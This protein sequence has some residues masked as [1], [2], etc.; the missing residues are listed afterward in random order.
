MIIGVDSLEEAIEY[1]KDSDI[2][3]ELIYQYRKIIPCLDALD[4]VASL[5]YD[6]EDKLENIKAKSLI[7]G[8]DDF[9]SFNTKNDIL[10]LKDMIKDLKII[11]KY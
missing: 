7:I 6:L 5:E 10:P 3:E 8:I 4:K 2:K 9:V 11:M 1:V